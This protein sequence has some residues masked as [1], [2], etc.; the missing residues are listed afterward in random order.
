MYR[1]VRNPRQASPVFRAQRS[2][3]QRSGAR[4]QRSGA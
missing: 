2:G 4:A 1:F 3:A